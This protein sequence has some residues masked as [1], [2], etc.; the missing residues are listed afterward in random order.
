M[1]A[2]EGSELVNKVW[3]ILDKQEEDKL[4]KFPHPGHVVER[5]MSNAACSSITESCSSSIPKLVATFGWKRWW[6]QKHP[7]WSQVESSNSSNINKSTKSTKG[8]PFSSTSSS[9]WSSV[10]LLL[11]YAVHKAISCIWMAYRLCLVFDGA[12]GWAHNLWTSIVSHGCSPVGWRPWWSREEMW[13]LYSNVNESVVVIDDYTCK[14]A[15]CKRSS[16]EIVRKIVRKL[17]LN[18][19]ICSAKGGNCGKLQRLRK[20]SNDE[21]SG[22]HTALQTQ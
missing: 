14:V 5:N 6:R 17:W 21:Y 4:I 19:C 3:I 15:C 16:I 10:E 9:L 1:R 8:S 7:K 11:T 20:E 2:R 12:W 22:R 18:S 13:R